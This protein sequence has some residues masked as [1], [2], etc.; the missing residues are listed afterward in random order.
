MIVER[1]ARTFIESWA[2]RRSPAFVRRGALLG[3]FV[4]AVSIRLWNLGE[5]NFWIDELSA[6]AYAAQPAD[7]LLG[8]LAHDPNM[9][10][11]YLMLAGW[12]QVVGVGA[13]EALLRLPSA[14]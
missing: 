14:L 1:K 5:R 8:V 11:Y 6:L 4:F 9:V 7:H 3:L 10:L 12:V 2:Q 13:S